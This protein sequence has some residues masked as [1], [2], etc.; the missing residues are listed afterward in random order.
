MKNAESSPSQH[1]VK[2]FF[3]WCWEKIGKRISRC[4]RAFYH[5]FL[6]L[7]VYHGLFLT[8]AVVLSILFADKFGGSVFSDNKN[9]DAREEK[10]ELVQNAHGTGTCRVEQKDSALARSAREAI[11]LEREKKLDAMQNSLT[12]WA[13][14]ITVVFVLFSV[15]G[16][17]EIDKRLKEA[18]KKTDEIGG[19]YKRIFEIFASIMFSKDTTNG[20]IGPFTASYLSN[21]SKFC[22]IDEDVP[23][24]KM[25]LKCEEAHARSRE[26]EFSAALTVYDEFKK[27]KDFESIPDNC[28]GLFFIHRGGVRMACAKV[29]W[30][31]LRPEDAETYAKSAIEDY[32]EGEK[33]AWDDRSH[34][35]FCVQA[36]EAALWLSEIKRSRN[37]RKEEEN[38]DKNEAYYSKKADKYF[39]RA[40]YFYPQKKNI[41]RIRAEHWARIWKSER[42]DSAYNKMI[43]HCEE[44]TEE[45]FNEKI[46]DEI[47]KNTIKNLEKN[48]KRI[49]D[50][51]QN[52][53]QD[54]FGYE[55]TIKL[56]E[57][58]LSAVLGKGKGSDKIIRKIIEDLKKE[59]KNYLKDKSDSSL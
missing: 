33:Y 58:M 29:C 49:L 44:M 52:N 25:Y 12:L 41:E 23:A 39:R 14:V 59:L 54:I 48:K 37:T 2:D 6:K 31:K 5:G 26:G 7:L 45:V 50:E 11:A 55:K 21:I 36:G 57:D 24:L 22:S 27:S 35:F 1:R 9:A 56:F 46:P 20:E 8:C 3:S 17:L 40:L 10:S 34:A 15:I 32:E 43:K 16:L 18:Q 28:K 4:W 38:N 30:S 47:I 51:H 13:T 53:G 19:K 42:D